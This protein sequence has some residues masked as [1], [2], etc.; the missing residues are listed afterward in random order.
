[1]RGILINPYTKT[2]NHVNV[3]DNIEEIYK[4]MSWLDKTVDIVQIG[5]NFPNGDQMLVDEEGLL[6][7]GRKVFRF[8]GSP[9]VGCGLILGSK[10]E[11]WCD[12][13]FNLVDIQA[14]V[15]FTDLVTTGAH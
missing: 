12:A 11:N 7:A 2:V 9:F 14:Y 5:M 15:G 3:D 8:N 6:K 4:A 13:S 1:M 10:G